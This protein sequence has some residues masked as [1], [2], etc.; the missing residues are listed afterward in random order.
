MRSP[1]ASSMP[2]DA[3][4]APSAVLVAGHA[5]SDPTLIRSATKMVNTNPIGAPITG[6]T[7]S[8]TM[9]TAMASTIVEVGR[10]LSLSRRPGT[11]YLIDRSPDSDQQG[12]DRYRPGE[13]GALDDRPEEHG[14]EDEKEA[15]KEGEHDAEKT[16]DDRQRDDKDPQLIH[17]G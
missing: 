14:S 5:C 13:R 7:N 9:D 8:P 12:E 1:A 17:G 11:M 15:G 16:G 2:I 10:P 3:A 4:T 6:T